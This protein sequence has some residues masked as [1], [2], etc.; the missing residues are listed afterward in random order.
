MIESKICLICRKW[1]SEYDKKLL[2]IQ[3]IC[4]CTLN[5]CIDEFNS[6]K[7][8]IE[9]IIMKCN[10]IRKPIRE[11]AKKELKRV[12]SNEKIL[13]DIETKIKIC[14]QKFGAIKKFLK[15]VI[16]AESNINDISDFKNTDIKRKKIIERWTY[17]KKLG[18]E[19]DEQVKVIIELMKKIFKGKWYFQ[20]IVIKNYY[21]IIKNNYIKALFIST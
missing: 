3:G 10:N 2:N 18:I 19:K 8:D 9:W 21:L 14:L 1:T 13:M 12:N 20:A 16:Y 11:G 15:D 4:V 6:N 17:L 5:K 7:K